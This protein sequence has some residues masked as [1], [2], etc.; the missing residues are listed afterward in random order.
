MTRAPALWFPLFVVFIDALGMGIIMPI[1]PDLLVELTGQTVAQSAFI[2]GIL[3]AVYALNQ[4]IFGPI[5]GALSDRFGRRPLILACLV[6]LCLDYL[7]MAVAWTVTLLFIGRFIAGIA[8]ASYSV[9]TA[10]I[11]DVSPRDKRSANFGLI[12]A[13]F[14][15]G[16][17]FGPMLGGLAGSIDVRA[18][19]YLAAFLCLVGVIFGLFVLPESLKD[20]N[21]RAFSLG[22]ANP[23]SSIKRAFLLPG[24][25][26][27]LLAYALIALS[28]FTYP[29]IWSYWGKETFDWSARTIGL[30]LTYYGI[31]TAIVQ[32]GLIRLMIPRFGEPLTMIFGLTCATLSAVL[33]GLS[34]ET[35]MVLA[36]IPLAC[37]SHVAQAAMTGMMTRRVSDSEQGELQGVI[38]SITAVASIGSPLVMTAIFFRMADPV[39][40]YVPGA[41]FLVAGM[42]LVVAA[43]PIRR[44]LSRVAVEAD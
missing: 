28:D 38:G 44:A 36:I 8:G 43:F 30:T 17:V 21:R 31:G 5:V 4:F 27:F 2:G 26:A 24:L 42:L 3:M 9:A 35:W 39:G 16:F 22:N 34:S 7:L 25:G 29:A 1:M 18:P 23:L 19:F 15:V 40:V 14:G 12:G 10:Y 41:P 20:S 13:A 37:L 11:A 6:T 33:F 32:G